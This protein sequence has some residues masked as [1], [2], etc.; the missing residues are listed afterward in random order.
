MPEAITDHSTIDRSGEGKRTVPSTKSPAAA[1]TSGMA[2]CQRLSMWR[3][4]LRATNTM[5][6]N[7]TRYGIITSR[8]T[9]VFEYALDRF[10]TNCGIQ[11][12][13]DQNPS[14]AAK[15]IIVRYQTRPLKSA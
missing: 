14:C 1:I 9:T 6:G 3:S 13:I 8:P 11:N 2:E 10:F 4:E 7:P 12:V 15:N 5:I